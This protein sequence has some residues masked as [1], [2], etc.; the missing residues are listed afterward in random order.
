MISIACSKVVVYRISYTLNTSCFY[1]VG[2]YCNVSLTFFILIDYPKH[3]DTV[4]L[5]N[6]PF[7]ILRDCPSNC[8]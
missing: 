6:C 4:R 5:W 7:C 8:L 2:C 1:A 3:I